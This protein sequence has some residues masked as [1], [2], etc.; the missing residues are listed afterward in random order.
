MAK[1]SVVSIHIAPSAETPIRSL[2]E[3]RAIAGK[4]LEGDRY[5]QATGTYS[6]QPGSGR[7]V[8]FIEIEAIEAL[9]RESNIVLAPGEARRN[10]VTRGIALNHLVGREF[11]VGEVRFRGL[12]LCEP[13]SHLEGL[14]GAGLKAGLH[15]R[16][17][18]RTDIITG[19]TIRV[20]DTVSTL[21]TAEE[22]N[23]DLI[24][25]Y[26]EEMWNLWD[27][28]MAEQILAAE[29]AFHGSLGVT[30]RGI[31]AF[32]EYMQ[33]VRDAFPDFHNTIEE[34][35]AENQ[36]VVARLTY[37]GTHRGEILGVAPTG[38]KITYA[39]AAFF[40]IADGK[41]T[42]GWVLGDRLSLLQQLVESSIADVAGAKVKK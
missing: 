32:R 15:H 22:Q 20:G 19:G 23:K 27:F 6:G 29:I 26:Y 5:L 36:S 41:I 17:G 4:G 12:R 42:K 11:R 37:R 28:G 31:A 38:R 8:T 13:C 9:E 18:L 2:H 25:R 34:L 24:R 40:Q 30:T 39:G 33:T 14:S 1:G 10:V 7:E 35:V 21:D 16:G 3:A